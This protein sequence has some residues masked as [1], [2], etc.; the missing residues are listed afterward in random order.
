VFRILL[1][2]LAASLFSGCQQ[3]ATKVLIGGTLRITAE[4]APIEDSIIVISGSTI[5]A[6]G[7][8]KD[9]PVPQDSERV[10]TVGKWILPGGPEPIA[11]GQPASLRLYDR[12]P[13]SGT[14]PV[15]TMKLGIWDR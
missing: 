12:D 11:A 13:Q 10:D 14:Q 9:V 7:L 8:R 4:A 6:V 15:R 5:R 3:S 1:V 2:I